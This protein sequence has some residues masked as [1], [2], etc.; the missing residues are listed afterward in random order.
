MKNEKNGEFQFNLKASN[1]Q[2]I[3]T[4]EGYVS[5]TNCINGIESVKRN[6]Q[7]ENK[8]DRKVST[9]KKYYFNL[10]A[11]NGQ[12]IGT[13]ELYESETGRDNGIRSV[14]DNAPDASIDDQS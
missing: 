1:G 9:N 5:K 10:K 8:F 13:S 2:I 12:I 4:S 11:T 14:K 6:S 3:L 7:D